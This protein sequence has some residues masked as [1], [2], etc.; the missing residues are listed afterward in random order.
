MRTRE[1]TIK[2]LLR[3]YKIYRNQDDPGIDELEAKLKLLPDNYIDMLE[4]DL[5]DD[6]VCACRHAVRIDIPPERLIY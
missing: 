6:V 4:G 2:I 3:E 5:Q 1:Q